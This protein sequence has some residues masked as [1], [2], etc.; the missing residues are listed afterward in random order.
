VGTSEDINVS[1]KH[2]LSVFKTEY[3]RVPTETK[4]VGKRSARLL[5]TTARSFHVTLCVTSIL[6]EWQFIVSSFM[7]PVSCN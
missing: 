5:V 6:R 2:T 4:V 7:K 3:N 1:E